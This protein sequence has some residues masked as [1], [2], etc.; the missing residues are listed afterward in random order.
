MA[1]ERHS[2]V[3][4]LSFD[5]LM[6]RN[7]EL[8]NDNFLF[9]GI[10]LDIEKDLSKH[11]NLSISKNDHGMSVNYAIKRAREILKVSLYGNGAVASKFI[12]ESDTGNGS[13]TFMKSH[14]N[15]YFDMDVTRYFSLG[16]ITVKVINPE[17]DW[18]GVAAPA[19]STETG[20]ENGEKDVSAKK[21]SASASK[22]SS[23]KS[24]PAP[25][26]TMAE[27]I[28]ARTQRICKESMAVLK[29]AGIA[30]G[31]GLTSAEVYRHAYAAGI[32]TITQ[33]SPSEIKNELCARVKG[34][35]SRFKSGILVGSVLV[36]LT[37]SMHL[38]GEWLLS[39]D[40]THDTPRQCLVT[41]CILSKAFKT[42]RML[43]SAQNTGKVGLSMEKEIDES[44]TMY[45]DVYFD[46]QGFRHQVAS[47]ADSVSGVVGAVVSGYNAST[48]VSASTDGVISAV[49]DIRVGDGATLNLS[50]ILSLEGSRVGIGFNLIA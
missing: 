29:Q 31:S 12:K 10:K 47:L 21:P 26:Q 9:S 46:V 17:I 40:R 28:K 11:T 35:A 19:A 30:V 14:T 2:S 37:P 23:P 39:L 38:G 44:T 33:A 45:T 13:I 34:A 41:T 49:S 5:R 32:K 24:I 16:S 25:T 36:P 48:K 7:K 18:S 6:N 50:T 15:S 20:A 42:W 1:V 8:H 27:Q 43:G 4:G 3:F 22:E